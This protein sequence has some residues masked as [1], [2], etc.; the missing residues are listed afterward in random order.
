MTPCKN[1]ITY[2]LCVGDNHK[3]NTPRGLK[4]YLH[5]CSLLKDFLVKN[6]EKNCNKPIEYIYEQGLFLE[7]DYKRRIYRPLKE[8]EKDLKKEN[9]L[10]NYF[11][12]YLGCNGDIKNDPFDLLLRILCYHKVCKMHNKNGEDNEN[13]KSII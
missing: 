6:I 9:F 8:I 5:K 10:L 11:E 7:K 2:A 1:C 12:G 4:Y 3:Y 13:Q